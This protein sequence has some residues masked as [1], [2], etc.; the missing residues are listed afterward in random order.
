MTAALT[1][2]MPPSRNTP[3]RSLHILRRMRPALTQEN[4]TQEGYRLK[5][6]DNH[7]AI[8]RLTLKDQFT[9]DPYKALALP[10][11]IV[12][13]YTLMAG[14]LWAAHGLGITDTFKND[15]LFNWTF[16]MSVA[17]AYSMYRLAA[18]SEWHIAGAI[19][20]DALQ[21]ALLTLKYSEREEGVYYP[22]RPMFTP[23]YRC[24][25][26]RIT[27]TIRDGETRLTGPHNKLK[28]LSALP[29]GD[30]A[31]TRVSGEVSEGL[32]GR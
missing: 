5:Q 19:N 29:L 30:A 32:G 18:L 9:V 23:L 6:S 24:D 7:T 2:S 20:P 13:Y 3:L 15:F 28:A 14:L 10:Q 22:K 1:I 25:S 31:G 4:T 26:E 16:G 8:T 12:I 11:A 21:N 27:V 17:T